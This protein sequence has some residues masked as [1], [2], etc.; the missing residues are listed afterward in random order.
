MEARQDSVD[1]KFS[2]KDFVKEMNL[3]EN[4]ITYKQYS[5]RW[6]VFLTVTMFNLCNNCLWICIGSVATKA[7]EYYEVQVDDID[8]ISSVFLYASIPC[9]FFLTWA[10]SKFGLM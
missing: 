6:G 2:K 7:A 10:E 3:Y 9:C 4:P 5:T 8:L 1:A